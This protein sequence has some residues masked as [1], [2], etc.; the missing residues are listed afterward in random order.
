MLDQLDVAKLYAQILME[1]GSSDPEKWLWRQVPE[2]GYRPAEESLIFAFLTQSF[3]R[4]DFDETNYSES[5]YGR[6]CI[7]AKTS[8]R[9]V[10]RR[11]ENDC[12][13]DDRIGVTVTFDIAGKLRTLNVPADRVTQQFLV[14]G[15]NSRTL[16]A[17]LDTKWRSEVEKLKSESH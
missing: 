1:E 5:L 8:V 6:L 12:D 16:F 17:Q 13:Y 11:R 3:G 15:I 4:Q 9:Q 14:E 2:L 10:L 7:L